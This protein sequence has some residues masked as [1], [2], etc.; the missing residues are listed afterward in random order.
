MTRSLEE[1]SRLLELL[2]LE[3]EEDLNQYRQRIER[4]PLAER[5]REGYTWYPLNLLRQGYTI[6]DRA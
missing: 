5:Q 4:L 2:K 1:L 3:W 6:G